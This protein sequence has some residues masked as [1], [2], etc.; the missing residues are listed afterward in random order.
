MASQSLMEAQTRLA[1]G[2]KQAAVS[3]D[4]SVSFLRLEIARGRLR[5]SRL[6][7]RLV[8][9][10]EELRRYLAQGQERLA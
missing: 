1:Y 6:S 2:L 9:T 3:L 7:R 4:V 10:D 5:P 8:I